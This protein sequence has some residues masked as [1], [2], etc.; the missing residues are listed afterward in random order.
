MS[1]EIHRRKVVAVVV[2][3][4]AVLSGEQVGWIPACCSART[5]VPLLRCGG[6]AA[7]TSLGVGGVGR[8]RAVGERTNGSSIIIFGAAD[9]KARPLPPTYRR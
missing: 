9:V 1:F 4:A 6:V 7:Q 8:V 3:T 2:S 5:R